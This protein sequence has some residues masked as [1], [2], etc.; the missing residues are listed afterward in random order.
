MALITSTG[1]KTNMET[2]A[3]IVGSA[4]LTVYIFYGYV[5][6]DLW[7]QGSYIGEELEYYYAPNLEREYCWDRMSICYSSIFYA[8]WVYLS[9]RGGQ[10]NS[11]EQ[12]LG[13]F[14]LYGI[15]IFPII[16]SHYKR[17]IVNIVFRGHDK[18]GVTCWTNTIKQDSEQIGMKLYWFF[19]DF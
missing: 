12:Y 4:C 6:R 17:F 1:T 8:S 10:K 16:I 13:K 3:D 14:L 11:K 9:L 5:C 19:C 2:L 18:A 7:L 15:S